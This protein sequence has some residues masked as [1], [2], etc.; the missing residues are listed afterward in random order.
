MQRLRRHPYLRPADRQ[1]GESTLQMGVISKWSKHLEAL[2]DLRLT[3]DH[4]SH[5]DVR[6]QSCKFS[7]V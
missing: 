3:L 7:R 1:M 2:H 5:S 6:M 4:T